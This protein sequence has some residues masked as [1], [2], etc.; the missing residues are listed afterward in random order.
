MWLNSIKKISKD[1]RLF[2]GVFVL[3]ILS[4]NNQD[5]GPI[6]MNLDHDAI[7]QHLENNYEQLPE[8]S[9]AIS[10]DSNTYAQYASPTNKYAHA[11]LGD[12]IE[13][14]ELV[15]YQDGQFY[16][17]LLD[18]EYV[19]EDIRPRLFDVDQDGQL[20]IITIRS[21]LSLGA[22]IV[23]YKLIDDAIVEYATIEEIGT[24]N[25]WLNIAAINDMDEDGIV[26][27]IWVQTPHIGGILKIAKIQ[28]GNLEVLSEQSQYSNHGIGERNLCLSA[29]TIRE[30]EKV[31]YVPN[32]SRTNITGF[33]FRNQ[34]LEAVDTIFQAVDFSTTL[35]SQ[36]LFEML[37]EDDVNCIY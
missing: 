15:V 18:D 20:E 24:S 34:E 11:I 12:D 30:A 9:I 31:I 21:N 35:S 26:E 16:S 29:L 25:K 36:F 6:D 10:S 5:D 7:I 8:K 13:G 32:Q 27:M 28:E 17:L 37:I 1:F 14:E 22:G 19:F 4:C 23:I 33:A 2:L 3:F